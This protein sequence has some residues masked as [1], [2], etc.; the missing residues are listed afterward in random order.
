MGQP[1]HWRAHVPTDVSSPVQDGRC[2]GMVA[3][4]PAATAAIHPPIRERTRREAMPSPT[5][6]PGRGSRVS[7]QRHPDSI[8]RCAREAANEA[9]PSGIQDARCQAPVPRHIRDAMVVERTSVGT[10][11]QVMGRRM[12]AIFPAIGDPLMLTLQRQHR[13]SSVPAALLAVGDPTL[14]HAQ[15]PLFSAIP[16]GGARPS[17]PRRRRSDWQCQQQSRPL[18]QLAATATERSR[19]RRAC[20]VSPRSERSAR[21]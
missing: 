9:A 1:A 19:A 17:R 5:P 3:I 11:D 21:A 18:G 20:P 16:S 14:R 15:A 13:R 7:Q 6:S 4:H 12:Q 10:C 2:S 8:R